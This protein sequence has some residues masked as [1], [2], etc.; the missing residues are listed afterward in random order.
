MNKKIDL[1]D[2]L[3]QDFKKLYETDILKEMDQMIEKGRKEILDRHV[4]NIR[5]RSP[6]EYKKQT[7]IAISNRS[8]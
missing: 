7:S 4:H 6:S 1:S 5:A 3:V 2:K 8:K